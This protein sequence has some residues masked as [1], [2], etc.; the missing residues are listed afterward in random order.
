[1][2][3]NLTALCVSGVF[4]VH[5]RGDSPYDCGDIN[6]NQGFQL[7][8]AFNYAIGVVNS[9][10]GPFSGKLGGLTIGGLGLDACE[11]A[12][13]AS[14]L[15]SNIHAGYL[16][17]MV[18]NFSFCSKPLKNESV[19]ISYVVT[20]TDSVDLTDALKK[21]SHLQISVLTI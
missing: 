10:Q 18:C 8:E 11:S 1:M 7:L 12:T 4:D 20:N 2:S 5:E 14:T 21:G 15:V 16:P 3:V 19:N 6:M 13:R 9:K 17:I